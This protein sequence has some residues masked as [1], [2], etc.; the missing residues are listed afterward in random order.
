MSKPQFKRVEDVYRVARALANV[1]P[2]KRYLG[3]QDCRATP[4]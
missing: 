2:V 3:G 4:A 1:T